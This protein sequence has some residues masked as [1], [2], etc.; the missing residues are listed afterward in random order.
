MYL[1]EKNNNKS[2]KI[3]PTHGIPLKKCTT[4]C[5]TGLKISERG[6]NIFN[7]P[8]FLKISAAPPARNPRILKKYCKGKRSNTFRRLK[9]SCTTL[10]ANALSNSSELLICPT[11]TMVFVMVVPM[12]API[13]IGIAKGIV[14]TLAAT[15]LTTRDVVRDEL[16]T[17]LV[18]S[19]PIKSPVKG[20]L[21]VFMIDSAKPFPISLKDPPI[22]LIL[23]MKM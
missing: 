16:W 4:K 3:M 21:V 14:R 20:L 19:I 22:I 17:T 9:K 5:A 2:E 11:E 1:R 18:A 13:T 8:T 10:A 12:F 7:P 23:N 15:R 6:L